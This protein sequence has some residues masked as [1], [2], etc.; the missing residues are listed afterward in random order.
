MLKLLKLRAAYIAQRGATLNNPHVTSS[1]L[2]SFD[3]TDRVLTTDWAAGLRE[4][5]KS[6]IQKTPHHPFRK[7]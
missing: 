5:A 7:L 3:G 4:I 2:R 6:Y 1:F